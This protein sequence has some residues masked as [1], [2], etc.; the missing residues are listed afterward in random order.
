MSAVELQGVHKAFGTNPIVRGVDLS[1][2]AGEFMVL[3]GPSGCGKTTLLRLVAGLEQADAGEIRIGGKRVNDAAPRDRDVGM[4]FQSYAL[5]PHMT[6]RENLAFALTLRKTPAAEI[7][8]RVDEAAQMLELSKLLDRRPKELSGGQRQRVAMGRAI[9]RRPSVFLFDE[10][11]SNL[12]AA[13]R[14]QMRG[15][16]ARLHQL[17][18]ST[19]IYVTHDQVEAMTLATR[20]AVFNQGVLQQQGAPL[21]LYRSPANRFVAG[22]L[23]SPSMCF[24]RGTVADGKIRGPGFA[25]PAPAGAPQGREVLAGV[26]PQSATLAADGDLRG[27]IEAVE[28]LGSDGFAYLKTPAGTVIARFEGAPDLAVGSAAA[29]S[30]APGAIHL[31]DAQDERAL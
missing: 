9:V 20:L 23:G 2:D 5:Y 21:E 12:D 30:I 27:E 31:F 3:V 7:S 18:K 24:L 4:V 13:L 29:I 1:I 28:R 17:L 6:V 14:V 8:K 10:P 26:R 11:L 15:E 22:F 19:M 16:L 25:L